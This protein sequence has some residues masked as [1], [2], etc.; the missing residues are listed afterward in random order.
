MESQSESGIEDCTIL[1]KTL[2]EHIVILLVNDTPV[3]SWEDGVG[4][5]QLFF[6]RKM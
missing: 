1:I 5:E 6:C 2:L 3:C 4:P